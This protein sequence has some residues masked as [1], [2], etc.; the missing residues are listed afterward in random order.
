[1]QDWRLSFSQKQKVR[2]AER[3]ERRRDAVLR[4]ILAENRSRRRSGRSAKQGKIPHD[5]S[6]PAAGVFICPAV[7]RQMTTGASTAD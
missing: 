5:S 6:S 3:P 7:P 1:M 4:R 2:L